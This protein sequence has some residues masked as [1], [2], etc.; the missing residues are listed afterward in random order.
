MVRGKIW[1]RAR[2]WAGEAEGA[3]IKAALSELEDSVFVQSVAL[4]SSTKEVL[5][6]P[7]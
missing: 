4:K 2:G 7:G 6:V 3:A 5:N 1:E